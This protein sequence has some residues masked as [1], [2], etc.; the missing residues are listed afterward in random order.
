MTVISI[1]YSVEQAYVFYIVYEINL[2][3]EKQGQFII[4][5]VTSFNI[6]LMLLPPVHFKI[7][8]NENTYSRF[9]TNQ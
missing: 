4:L 9:Y 1:K 3:L 8:S 6:N 7:Q 5:H 2:V